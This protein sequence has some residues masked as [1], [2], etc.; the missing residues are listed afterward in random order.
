MSILE[1]IFRREIV[2][3]RIDG[4]GC[5]YL[6]ASMKSSNVLTHKNKY[7][8]RIYTRYNFTR[9]SIKI[10]CDSFLR[11]TR[12][13]LSR[14]RQLSPRDES[15]RFWIRFRPY[16]RT[17]KLIRRVL[18]ISYFFSTTCKDREAKFHRLCATFTVVKEKRKKLIHRGRI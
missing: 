14:V 16:K 7:P 12:Q 13:M 8:S 6:Y 2:L 3:D 10:N 1:K 5:L 15:T 9:A 11:A 18:A 4:R 17:S